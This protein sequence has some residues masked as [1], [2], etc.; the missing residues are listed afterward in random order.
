MAGVA[1]QDSDHPATAWQNCM[2]MAVVLLS[3]ASR[4]AESSPLSMVPHGNVLATAH[5]AP[6]SHA[7]QNQKNYRDNIRPSSLASELQ[8]IAPPR[9]NT[10][11]TMSPQHAE[12]RYG[13]HLGGG[14][15]GP[16]RQ[17]DSPGSG[18]RNHVRLRKAG[19]GQEGTVQ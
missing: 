9:A 3:W 1:N 11:C 2:H 14:G 10:K 7:N 5:P 8:L 12:G 15:G 6:A 19:A 17:Q 16:G 4:P 13:Q 18:G